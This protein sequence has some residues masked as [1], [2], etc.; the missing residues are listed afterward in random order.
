M[1][2][3]SALDNF[4]LLP[5]PKAHLSQEPLLLSIH[6]D[7]LR[8]LPLAL[9][10]PWAALTLLFFLDL[11]LACGDEE[12]YLVHEDTTVEQVFHA[13]REAIFLQN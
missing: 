1:N 12:A 4:L 3:R 7:R 10:T 5:N 6:L 8:A 2:R 11:L 9:L 13:D